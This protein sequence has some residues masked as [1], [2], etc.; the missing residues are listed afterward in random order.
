MTAKRKKTNL[1]Q[2][3]RALDT[4]ELLSD[5]HHQDVLQQFDDGQALHLTDLSLRCGQSPSAIKR[6]LDQLKAADLVFSPKRYPLA[7]A[8]NKLKIV[9]IALRIKRCIRDLSL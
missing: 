9:R 1:L 5:L 3:Q 2:V 8:A 6:K 7:Y 4:L